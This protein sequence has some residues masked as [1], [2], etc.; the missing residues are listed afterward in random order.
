MNIDFHPGDL[1]V[2]SDQEASPTVPCPWF[3]VCPVPGFGRNESKCAVSILHM[4]PRNRVISACVRIEGPPPPRL[5]PVPG[6]KSPLC[7]VSAESETS[8]SCSFTC[9]RNQVARLYSWREKSPNRGLNPGPLLYKS[10]TLPLSYPDK[11]IGHGCLVQ[12]L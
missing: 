2:C 9:M 7:L 5:C 4:H 1:G 8:Q 3:E 11:P 6:L 12:K 10:S